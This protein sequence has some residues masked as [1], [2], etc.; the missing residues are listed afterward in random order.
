[1]IEKH[2][3]EIGIKTWNF[4]CID[5]ETHH[6]FYES[7]AKY[8]IHLLNIVVKFVDQILITVNYKELVSQCVF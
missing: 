1:M 2:T 6:H 3:S 7:D 5:W 4:T 8:V